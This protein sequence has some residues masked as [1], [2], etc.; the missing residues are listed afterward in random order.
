MGNACYGE[1]VMGRS[2]LVASG[3]QNGAEAEDFADNGDAFGLNC[4]P[5]RGGVK[6]FGQDCVRED[7]HEVC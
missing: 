3:S 4:Y 1:E 6:Q 2:G 5:G 7:L